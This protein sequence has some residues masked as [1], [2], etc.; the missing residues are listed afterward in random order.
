MISLIQKMLQ[1]YAA[2]ALRQPGDSPL[3]VD[4]VI[5]ADE[6]QWEP[7]IRQLLE[8]DQ[9]TE[10]DFSL[11]LQKKME[12]TVLGQSSGSYKQRVQVGKQCIKGFP[13]SLTCPGS[14]IAFRCCMYR[15]ESDSVVNDI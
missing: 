3:P 2:Q 15:A 4:Q 9:T 14:Q 8:S 10:S 13:G 6:E 1:L 11:E 7:L 12:G 5:Q